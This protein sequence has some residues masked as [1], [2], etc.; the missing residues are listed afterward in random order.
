[1]SQSIN[2]MY[3]TDESGLIPFVDQPDIPPK[4]YSAMQ[5]WTLCF[6][7][8]TGSRLVD[9]D[10]GTSFVPSIKNGHL[11][12]KLDVQR[13]FDKA[14]KKSV[15]YCIPDDSDDLHVVNAFITDLTV[16]NTDLER[17]L[18]IY[19]AF[20]FSDGTETRTYIEI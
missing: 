6:L 16:D 7:T 9:T 12:T 13:A 10:F 3:I 14:N 19:I 1:M 5:N 2:V 20:Q 18:T 17:R 4:Y 8:S 11:F 15:S